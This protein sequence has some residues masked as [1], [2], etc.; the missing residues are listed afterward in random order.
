MR[1]IIFLYTVLIVFFVMKQQY[2]LAGILLI[3]TPVV[4]IVRKNIRLSKIKKYSDLISKAQE[5]F[6]SGKEIEP[7]LKIN[8]EPSY[9][10]ELIPRLPRAMALKIAN[11]R[12]KG[13]F[14]T[15]F[16]DFAIFTGIDAQAYEINKKILRFD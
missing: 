5:N 3:T 7:F 4:Y 2:L 6:N 15:D 13:K 9:I 16:N 8:R 10:L 11:E 14:L 12:R 1:L